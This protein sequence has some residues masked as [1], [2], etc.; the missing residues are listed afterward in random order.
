[1][2]SSVCCHLKILF[3]GIGLGMLRL[4]A[5][6]ESRS[7]C[8]CAESAGIEFQSFGAG[9]VDS[10]WCGRPFLHSIPLWSPPYAAALSHNLVLLAIVCG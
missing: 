1:M 8:F 2:N 7:A 5:T 4:L 9:G 6:L 3:I 10:H